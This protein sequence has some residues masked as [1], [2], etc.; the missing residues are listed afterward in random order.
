MGLH[1]QGAL[2]SVD[3]TVGENHRF[4]IGENRH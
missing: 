3:G 2:L 4:L 1:G